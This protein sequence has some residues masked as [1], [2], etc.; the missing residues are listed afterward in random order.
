MLQSGE[1]FIVYGS[2]IHPATDL[3]D[4]NM[5]AVSYLIYA[6]TSTEANN[7]VNLLV[8]TFKRQDVAAS[9]V[10]DWLAVENKNRGVAFGSIR[11]VMAEKAEPADEEGGMV[12]ALVMLEAKYVITAPSEIQTVF[13]TT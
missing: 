12:S 4:L 9:D 13:T 1:A 5:E 3:Y 2:A 8:E 11:S 10:N 6:P 7:I